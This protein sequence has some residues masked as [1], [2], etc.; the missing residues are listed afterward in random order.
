MATEDEF[1]LGDDNGGIDINPAELDV[2]GTAEPAEPPA[3][4]RKQRSDAGKPRGSRS[5]GSGSTSAGRAKG[6]GKAASSLDLSALDGLLIGAHALLAGFTKEDI[7]KLEQEEAHRFSGALENVAR[8]Y[9]IQTSQKTVDWIALAMVAGGIYGTRVYA[10][11]VKKS[12]AKKAQQGNGFDFNA[13]MEKHAVP[14]EGG[15]N[16]LQ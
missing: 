8:H 6:K 16:P 15:I 13:L 4:K 5:G 10:I 2:A 7:W 3:R 11:S 9:D 12:M 1:E 14:L